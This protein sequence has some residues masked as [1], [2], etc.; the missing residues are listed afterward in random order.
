MAATDLGQKLDSN[1]G[2]FV[3]KA[4]MP[5]FAYFETLGP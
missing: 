3:V 4:D 1:F 5:A 2:G